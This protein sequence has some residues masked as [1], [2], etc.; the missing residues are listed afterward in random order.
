MFRRARDGLEKKQIYRRPPAAV[1][2]CNTGMPAKRMNV[3]IVR[4]PNEGG[5]WAA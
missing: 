1:R 5:A 2:C 4:D 3:V